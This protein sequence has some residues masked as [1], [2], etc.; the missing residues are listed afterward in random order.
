MILSIVKWGGKMRIKIDKLFYYMFIFLFPI[1]P[2]FTRIAGRA[3]F[4]VPII[5]SMIA[6]IFCSRRIKDK[7]VIKYLFWGIMLN[8]IMYG[9]H[10]EWGTVVSATL[11]CYIVI[12]LIYNNIKNEESLI[13]T[14]DILLIAGIC[15]CLEAIIFEWFFN[16]NIFSLIQTISK[17]TNVGAASLQY[18]YGHVR[19]E[20]SLGQCIPF[21]MYCLF[22]N[23]LSIIM[24][25]A[26]KKYNI[27]PKLLYKIAYILSII[28]VVMT[29]S[30]MVLVLLV[31]LQC[32]FAMTL[33]KGKRSL[34]II[35]GLV[36]AI[37]VYVYTMD[38]TDTS[39]IMN[40]IYTVVSIFNPEYYSKLNDGGQNVSYRLYLFTALLPSIKQNLLFGL[41]R[42]AMSTFTF[43]MKT[44]VSSW[45]AY[46]IDNNY[47]SYLVSYGIIGLLGNS[48][49]LWTNIIRIG[50]KIKKK[51]KKY[52]DIY[53]YCLVI[54]ILYAIDILAVYQMGEK[55]I[56]YVLVGVFWAFNRIV[57]KK[58]VNGCNIK[59]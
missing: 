6:T 23:F 40:V 3:S 41:G 14:I 7:K 5:L 35:G 18:R 22:I 50:K 1:L 4:E 56:F 33:E 44:S 31:I 2:E 54:L 28:S 17:E 39:I 9:A 19:V 32:Y 34:I 43:D 29:G 15:M 16:F 13:K 21:A 27:T 47:L 10:G 49:L 12:L 25:N 38:D 42:S 30:R 37:L 46:S 59:K 11:H 26:K 57:E 53:K 58:E 36:A 8:I 55:R 24:L 51:M 48:Y 20:G 52:M 45:R